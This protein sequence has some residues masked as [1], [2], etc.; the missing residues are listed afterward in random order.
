MQKTDRDP[1]LVHPQKTG[2]TAEEEFNSEGYKDIEALNGPQE[3][4]KRTLRGFAYHEQIFATALKNYGISHE[5]LDLIPSHSQ[6][7]NKWD[8]QT[9]DKG[10]QR[11]K[12][13]IF[14]L[15]PLMAP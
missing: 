11:I 5:F 1:D 7:V 12:A 9:L 2:E 14:N 13:V 15:F 6:K 10:V 3:Q 4:L 8:L